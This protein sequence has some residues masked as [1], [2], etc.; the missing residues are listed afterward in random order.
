[1]RM[2][3]VRGVDRNQGMLLPEA[4]E[5][6]VSEENP[7]RAIEAFVEGLELK[8]LGFEERKEG[9]VGAPA[10]DMR[11]FL[12]LY[13]YGYL[14]RV[15]SSRELE[16]ATHRNLEVIWLMR[17]LKPD[18]WTISEFRRRWCKQFKGLFRQFNVVCGSLGLFGGQLVAIDGCYLKAVNAKAKNFTKARLEGLLEKIDAKTEEYLEALETADK[19]VT[20]QGMDKG[21]PKAEGLRDKLKKLES[22][23][24]EYE[25][26]LEAASRSDTGQVSQTD[27][28]SRYLKKSNQQVVGYNAQSAV[29]EKNHLIVEQEV[30]QE[31]SDWKL[32]APMAVAA[33]QQLGVEKL[34]VVADAGYYSHEQM[35]ECA[36]QGVEATVPN[37]QG[38]KSG[39]GIYGLES[40]RHCAEK[41]VYVCPQ[42]RELL[43]HEDQV[44]RAN[45][46][47][48][49]YQKAACANCPLKAK[50]TTG[51]Y[52]KL[53][54]VSDHEFIDAIQ[55]RWRQQPDLRVRRSQLV[56]HP[57]GTIKFWW[58][59]HALLCRG[60][61]M[62]R[63]EFSLS[64][65]AYNFRRALT[66][67][68]STGLAN[69]LRKFG[70][71]PA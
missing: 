7:V 47:R 2:S 12:K 4:V 54:V 40:F 65:L 39:E 26:L 37:R 9:A 69:A 25:A 28:D 19:E 17:Q 24:G 1:V 67:L 60:L 6:Y 27:T 13:L 15:R 8:A 34:S 70:T 51:T 5:D 30:T 45:T 49:Y 10:Y 23:R 48:T 35:R 18:H 63:A 58:G 61:E 11:A 52:R 29:D 20:A 16:K 68:G 32:L 41:D 55:R 21:G 62:V 56:E 64:A 3:Y 50:C 36:R 31:P 66:L 44:E 43:R 22:R 59:A 14:N 71:L 46:Y 57:F 33:K 42:G 38:R 53:R